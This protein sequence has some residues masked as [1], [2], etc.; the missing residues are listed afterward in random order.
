ME[1]LMRVNTKES[2]WLYV[3]HVLKETP[4]HAYALKKEIEGKFGFTTGNMTVYKVLYL[5]SRGGYVSKEKEGRRVIYSVTEKGVK[6][7]DEAKEF[8][9]KQ[10]ERL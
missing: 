10:L 5:L 6:A 9:R 8:Y 4:M 1:R 7:L 3:I 2:L